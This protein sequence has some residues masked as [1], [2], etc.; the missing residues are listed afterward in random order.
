MLGSKLRALEEGVWD[1][2][3][4]FQTGTGF[5]IQIS[6]RV[7]FR[8][9]ISVCQYVV[10]SKCVYCILCTIWGYLGFLKSV[11]WYIGI[12]D[13]LLQGPKDIAI[14]VDELFPFIEQV[15]EP[16]V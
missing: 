4:K 7:G 3:F 8:I 2:G 12:S 9:Q 6:N 11:Y 15:G 5:R 1:S 14:A 16:G 13:P 10:L